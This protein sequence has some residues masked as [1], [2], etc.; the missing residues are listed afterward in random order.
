MLVSLDPTVTIP[1][2]L[3]KDIGEPRTI[4][5]LGLFDSFIAAKLQSLIYNNSKAVQ[6]QG[7]SDITEVV[8]EF[9]R[10]GLKGVKNYNI[11]F[12]T[13]EINVPKIGKRTVASDEFLRTLKLEWVIELY[14]ELLTMNFLTEQDSKNS[15]TPLV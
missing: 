13:E 5:E 10:H 7:S 14:T 12:Q 4:W 9:V 2:S 1:Y 15:P 6:E 11:P 3:K 8:F